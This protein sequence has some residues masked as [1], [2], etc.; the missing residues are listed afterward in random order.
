MQ[1]YMLPMMDVLTRLLTGLLLNGHCTVMMNYIHGFILN[2]TKRFYPAGSV[3]LGGNNAA[4]VISPKRCILYYRTSKSGNT[5]PSLTDS[6]M[7]NQREHLLFRKAFF[8]LFSDRREMPWIIFK[9]TR[10]PQNGTLQL[11]EV[12]VV[13]QERLFLPPL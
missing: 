3:V 5:P 1:H 9:I 11:D 8:D 13:D 2:Y 10:L 7:E 4:G 12:A 6:V